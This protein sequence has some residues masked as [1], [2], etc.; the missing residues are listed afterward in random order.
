MN[1]VSPSI[2]PCIHPVKAQTSEVHFT[3][4]ALYIIIQ[5]G[6][7]HLKLFASMVAQ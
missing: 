2:C 5:E 3:L 7:E 1:K 6:V 4:W